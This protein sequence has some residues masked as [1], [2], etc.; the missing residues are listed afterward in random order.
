MK[1]PKEITGL[2]KEVAK[3]PEWDGIREIYASLSVGGKFRIKWEENNREPRTAQEVLEQKGGDCSDLGYFMIS[4]LKEL[5]RAYDS[6]D[7]EIGAIKIHFRGDPPE[8][9][10]LT[11][12][13][14]ATDIPQEMK[15][16]LNDDQKFQDALKKVGFRPDWQVVLADPQIG[17]LGKMSV[18]IDEY[19]PVRLT[20]VYSAYY[21]E[22]GAFAKKSNDE[23]FAEKLL[24]KAVKMDPNN[25]NAHHMLNVMY[26]KKNIGMAIVH[27]EAAYKLRPNDEVYKR[28]YMVALT[29]AANV[30]STNNDFEKALSH[31]KQAKPLMS[32][33]ET[34]KEYGFLY[35]NWGA[36]LHSLG[37]QGDALKKFEASAGYGQREAIELL[38]KLG[39]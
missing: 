10:H 13:I 16:G 17:V 2:V 11:P 33:Q 5:L 15:S 35:Y 19:Y 7:I 22:Q 31:L 27:A 9:W 6:K 8:L 1:P 21:Q 3:K 39:K 28:N 26:N 37:K 38:R 24:I 18:D 36:Y 29:N 32:E 14:V 25:F 20:G 23:K 34:T 4:G 12:I 30:A